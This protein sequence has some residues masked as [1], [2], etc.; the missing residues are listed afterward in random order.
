MS[1]ITNLEEAEGGKDTG[2]GILRPDVQPG[3]LTLPIEASWGLC[4]EVSHLAHL[5]PCM[6]W[7]RP[8]TCILERP[9]GWTGGFY[10]PTVCPAHTHSLASRHRSLSSRVWSR[11]VSEMGPLALEFFKSSESSPNSREPK[12]R[13]LRIEEPLPELLCLKTRKIPYHKPC[14]HLW[15]MVVIIIL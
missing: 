15:K 9:T 5:T 11:A 7:E 3:S 2:L 10:R 13:Q 14:F 4:Q 12:T 6:S 1:E 8:S